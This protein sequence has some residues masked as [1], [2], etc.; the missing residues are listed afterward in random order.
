MNEEFIPI[1]MFIMLGVVFGLMYYFRYKNRTETQRTIRLA[2][3]KGEALTPEL[4]SSL[5]QPT[6]DSNRDLRR[7]L[8]WMALGLGTAILAFAIPDDEAIWIILASSSFPGLIGIAYLIM[9]RFGD[10][11]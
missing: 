7:G 3:D 10:K 4:I 11:S 1:V 5:G 8:I 9:W 2:L 6:A